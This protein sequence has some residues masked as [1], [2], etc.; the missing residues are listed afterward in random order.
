VQ[1]DIEDLKILEVQSYFF[2]VV[3]IFTH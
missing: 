3:Y 1:E 2:T